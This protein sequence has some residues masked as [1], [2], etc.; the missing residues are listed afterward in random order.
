MSTLFWALASV[1]GLAICVVTTRRLWNERTDLPTL[2]G[3][4]GPRA[5]LGVG[6]DI[7][8]HWA[9][10]V[11]NVAAAVFCVLVILGALLELFGWS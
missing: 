6:R 4:E 10:L 1:V 11:V 7:A 8:Q 9:R 2:A 3:V 5:Q